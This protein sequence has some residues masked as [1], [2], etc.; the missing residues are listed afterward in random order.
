MVLVLPVTN[1]ERDLGKITFPSGSQNR[2]VRMDDVKGIS[3]F[4]STF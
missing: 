3:E 2:R 1:A 4:G